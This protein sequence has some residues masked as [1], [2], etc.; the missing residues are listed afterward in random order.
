ML[1]SMKHDYDAPALQRFQ[2]GNALE[3]LHCQEDDDSRDTTSIALK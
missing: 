3:I 2:A 1:C